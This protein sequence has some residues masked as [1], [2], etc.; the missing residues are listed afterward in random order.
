[1]Y[2]VCTVSI[3][4]EYTRPL[5]TVSHV[6]LDKFY[7]IY[8]VCILFWMLWGLWTTSLSFC[9]LNTEGSQRIWGWNAK[10]K[11]NNV[12]KVKY[13]EGIFER[14]WAKGSCIINLNSTYLPATLKNPW[15]NRNSLKKLG[16]IIQEAHVFMERFIQRFIVT[17]DYNCLKN[18]F[19]DVSLENLVLDQLIIPWLNFFPYSIS[20]LFCLI[21]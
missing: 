21:L 4:R 5:P 8:T 11:K 13:W 19:Y 18:N 17:N 1:M 20:S 14:N 10:K 6:A 7:S 2:T 12:K 9:T 15:T 16:Q 3:W